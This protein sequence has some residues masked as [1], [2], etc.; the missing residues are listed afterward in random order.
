M[1]LEVQGIEE[2]EITDPAGLCNPPVPPPSLP[3]QGNPISIFPTPT[4]QIPTSMPGWG[5]PTIRPFPGAGDVAVPHRPSIYT[6]H[7]DPN[8]PNDPFAPKTKW[9]VG[10]EAIQRAGE[11]VDPDTGRS[12]EER[13]DG[14]GNTH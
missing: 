14:N 4:P 1:K 9:G 11:Q 3:R 12:G 13:A 6:R 8:D 10:G 7:H 2:I 5:D